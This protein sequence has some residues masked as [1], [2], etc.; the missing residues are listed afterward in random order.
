MNDIYRQVIEQTKKIETLLVD[1]LGAQ[2]RG[3]HEKTDSIEALLSD[4]VVKK[5]RYIASVRNKLMHEDGYL[6]ENINHYISQG[7]SVIDYLNNKKP[8]VNHL[9][10]NKSNKGECPYCLNKSSPRLY[11]E[12]ASHLRTEKKRHICVH[13]GK[14]MYIT[15][16]HLTHSAVFFIY[17]VI[18]LII[19][20]IF[21]VF[22]AENLQFFALSLILILVI[23]IASNHYKKNNASS[24][25]FQV[26]LGIMLV[27]SSFGAF[28]VFSKNQKS[29]QLH[30]AFEV[31]GFIIITTYMIY[32]YYK[33]K[34]KK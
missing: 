20:Y 15:G 24:P 32:W 12:R 33:H 3:L 22:V 17:I 23:I 29:F 18:Y 19:G 5:I 34:K 8:S 10:S 28:I 7:D 1:R 9:S 6:I 27:F 14:D 2:G 31:S 4:N 30:E 21:S 13:C 11:I 26:L 25:F 16:G